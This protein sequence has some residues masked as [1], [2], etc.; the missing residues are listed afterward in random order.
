[1][2]RFFRARIE[3]FIQGLRRRWGIGLR[4]LEEQSVGENSRSA[5]DRKLA[6]REEFGIDRQIA[7]APRTKFKRLQPEIQRV[8]E[9]TVLHL[10][11]LRRQ[12]RALGPEDGF[13]LLHAYQMARSN[14]QV[15][16]C[17]HF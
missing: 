9:K 10:E 7:E 4:D 13:Q 8:F 5:R 16:G 2:S 14:K 17:R 6:I 11:M 15:P 12:E 3:E 1:M